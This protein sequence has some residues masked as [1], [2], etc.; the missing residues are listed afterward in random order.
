MS[1]TWEAYR[2]RRVHVVCLT[3]RQ[4]LCTSAVCVSPHVREK[5]SVVETEQ[6]YEMGKK[7]K[8][9]LEKTGGKK[10]EAGM[11]YQGV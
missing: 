11:L 3:P 5:L 6:L 8:T 4:C 1:A 10:G 2:D 9:K 7:K